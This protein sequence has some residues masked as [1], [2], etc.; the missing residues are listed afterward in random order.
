MKHQPGMPCSL[1]SDPMVNLMPLWDV[2]TCICLQ[3][4]IVRASMQVVDGC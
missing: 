3:S 1:L 2:D 4:Q